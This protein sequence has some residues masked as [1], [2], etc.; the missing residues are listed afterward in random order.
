MYEAEQNQLITVFGNAYKG[1]QHWLRYL[2]P[3]EVEDLL[4][5]AGVIKKAQETA[6]KRQQERIGRT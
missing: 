1:I 3:G 2:Q 4:R 5:A 6:L